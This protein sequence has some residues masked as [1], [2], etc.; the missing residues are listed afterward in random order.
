M[1]RITTLLL[2]L[3]FSTFSYAQNVGT[4]PFNLRSQADV[5]TFAANNFTEINGNIIMT[6]SD[7]TNLSGLSTLTKING[8]LNISNIGATT[9][10]GLQNITEA[11]SGL[12][13][14][15]NG[16]LSDLSGLGKLEDADI[17]SIGSNRNLTSLSGLSN[18]LTEVGQLFILGNARLTT[19]NGL[20]QLRRVTEELTVTNNRALSDCSILCTILDSSNLSDSNIEI[21]GNAN[22]CLDQG[23]L[24]SVCDSNTI[25]LGNRSE[26]N[27]YNGPSTISGNLFITYKGTGEFA[28]NLDALTG[29]IQRINGDLLIKNANLLTNIDGLQDLIFVGGD[30]R[31]TDNTSLSQFCG[32]ANLISR[33]GVQGS[34]VI[35]GNNQN[36]TP[37]QIRNDNRCQS[38]STAEFLLGNEIKTFPIPADTRITFSSSLRLKSVAVYDVLGKHIQSSSLDSDLVLDVSHLHSGIYFL[39]IETTKGRALKQ[40]IVN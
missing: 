22:V 12:V 20:S 23:V 11:S 29:K 15:G 9:L 5:N 3:T 13:I 18:Q 31:I 2:I 8:S 33:N 38:L 27:N 16:N 17:I 10:N 7:I 19:L 25:T 34:I 28:L 26:V 36:P 39:Q 37:Q 35:E 40:V 21:S 24:E 1:K 14:S 4:G 32:I 6:G 30:V